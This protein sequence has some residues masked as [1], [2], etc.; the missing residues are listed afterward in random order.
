MSI[1]GLK[2]RTET[3]KSK[4]GREKKRKEEKRR[5][6]KRK[7][8]KRDYLSTPPMSDFPSLCFIGFDEELKSCRFARESGCFGKKRINVGRKV[9]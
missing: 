2:I 6:K 3:T 5:E 1:Q 7:E 9:P 8:E 4:K